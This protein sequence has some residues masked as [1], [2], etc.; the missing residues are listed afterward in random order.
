M[1]GSIELFT[2]ALGG[3]FFPVVFTVICPLIGGIVSTL[4]NSFGLF[5]SADLA[6]VCFY[7]VSSI[8][9]FGGNNSVIEIVGGS[10]KMLLAACS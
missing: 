1:S 6:G 7:A 4:G 5:I 3:A 8:C 10:I 2:A 9:R